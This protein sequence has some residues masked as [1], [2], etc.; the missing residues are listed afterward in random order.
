MMKINDHDD[1]D[2]DDADEDMFDEDVYSYLDSNELKEYYIGAHLDGFEKMKPEPMD[3]VK[4][5]MIYIAES[6]FIRAIVP[7]EATMEVKEK[8][9]S[10]LTSARWREMVAEYSKGG[11]YRLDDILVFNFTLEKALV[12]PFLNSKTPP[13]PTPTTPDR[14][15]PYFKSALRRFQ[16]GE[17]LVLEP[18]LVFFHRMNHMYF[19]YKKE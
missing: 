8:T 2:V 5:W 1:H 19:I 7:L 10:I 16:E 13:P 12:E 18:S 4:V 6:N 15:D 14:E 11:E 17:N 9:T 3:R